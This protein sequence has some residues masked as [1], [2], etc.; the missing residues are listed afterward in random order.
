[1]KSKQIPVISSPLLQYCGNLIT[2]LLT[3]IKILITGIKGGGGREEDVQERAS[4]HLSTFQGHISLSHAQFPAKLSVVK[5]NLKKQVKPPSLWV[6]P[7]KSSLHYEHT[8]F[9][10][11]PSVFV[12]SILL[13]K[14]V[15]SLT[16]RIMIKHLIFSTSITTQNTPLH[17]IKISC[18]TIVLAPSQ[19]LRSDYS[20]HNP[21]P[22]DSA[23]PL[24]NTDD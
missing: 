19:T 12:K 24:L 3:G 2:S 7:A 18:L 15:K 8:T 5:S 14:N 23:L 22:Q 16:K 4:F 17:L 20:P 9:R 1:M 10:K 21:T 6:L 13:E 11:P